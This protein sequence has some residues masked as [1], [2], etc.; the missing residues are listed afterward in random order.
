M[1]IIYF[2]DKNL[3]YVFIYTSRTK[4]KDVAAK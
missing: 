1:I 3:R 4:T 2:E